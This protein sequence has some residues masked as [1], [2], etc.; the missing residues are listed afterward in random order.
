MQASSFIY[1]D[2]IVKSLFDEAPAR[3]QD[4]IG[5]YCR[6]IL[7]PQPRRGDSTEMAAI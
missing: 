3:Y 2:S 5:G 4:R 7:E 6:V 1:D